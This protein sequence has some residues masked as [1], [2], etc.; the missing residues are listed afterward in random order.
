MAAR[1]YIPVLAAALLAAPSAAFAQQGDPE[2]PDPFGDERLETYRLQL[3]WHPIGLVVPEGRFRFSDFLRMHPSG[4]R[5]DEYS[6]YFSPTYGLGDGW[7]ITA[8]VMGAER[9]GRGGNALFYGAGVQKQILRE[10]ASRPAVSVGAYGMTGPHDHHSGTL[11]L[12]S[13]KQ[14]YARRS[15]AVFLHGGVKFEAFDS[16]DYGNGTGVR[17]YV[18]A[19]AAL[20]RRMTIS[21]EYSPEQPW[22]DTSMYAARVTYRF[23]KRFG[24]TGGIRN[25]GFENETFISVA[26]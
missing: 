24:V 10:T 25:N 15:R 14:V 12:S 20:S 13:T 19:T 8:G 16:D 4:F 7:E 2:P 11:F 9:I 6:L 23:Y 17:P 22:E 1:L 5:A 26:L 21:G 3:D 18:G